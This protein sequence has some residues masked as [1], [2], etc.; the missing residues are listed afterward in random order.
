LTPVASA[1]WGVFELDIHGRKMS[2]RDACAC[3][4]LRKFHHKGGRE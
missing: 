1:V 3:G 2:V 4:V